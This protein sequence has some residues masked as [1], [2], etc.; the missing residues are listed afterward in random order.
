MANARQKA[1]GIRIGTKGGTK[2]LGFWRDEWESYGPDSFVQAAGGI[3]DAI[4]N[5]GQ[6]LNEANRNIAEKLNMPV[7]EPQVRAAKARA[8]QRQLKTLADKLAQIE[9]NRLKHENGDLVPYR[10]D[11]NPSEPSRSLA[12]RAELRRVFRELDPTQRR[13]A[14]QDEQ[15][16]SAILEMPAAVSGM[17]RTEH[18]DLF[19]AEREAKFGAELKAVAD[20][21]D[22]IESAREALAGV[23]EA[24]AE[25]LRTIGESV[26]EQPAPKPNKEWA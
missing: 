22:A 4:L 15:F 8:A 10:Y 20:G 9:I 17:S 6:P 1:T 19:R 12:G 25:E 5:I 3:R 24:F 14:L 13:E 18:A 16:R 26:E 11:G 7:A 21:K 23:S 2:S